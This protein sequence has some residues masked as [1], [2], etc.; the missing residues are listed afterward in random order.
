ME[1]ATFAALL[2]Y[3][4]AGLVEADEEDA[5]EF[6]ACAWIGAEAA[7]AALRDEHARRV[8]AQLC[9][10]MTEPA[11]FAAYDRSYAL[12]TRDIVGSRCAIDEMGLVFA[13]GRVSASLR[14][15]I[16]AWR[17]RAL[18]LGGYWM[19]RDAARVRPGARYVLLDECR[20]LCVPWKA[21]RYM[22][23]LLPDE[24]A[25]PD[26]ALDLT[27]HAPADVCE[28]VHRTGAP[29]TLGITAVWRRL[30]AWG[31]LFGAQPKR[32]AGTGAASVAKRACTE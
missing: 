2:T 5:G 8:C 30:G 27:R 20:A 9:E 32:G 4:R 24:H 6:V 12:L 28:A 22:Q 31:A 29:L 15:V 21:A 26:G 25:T 11:L 23:A 7:I 1:D 13:H 14:P 18:Q 3:M 17:T 10:L 19:T 16:G